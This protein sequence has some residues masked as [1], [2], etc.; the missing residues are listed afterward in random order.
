MPET[1][2]NSGLLARFKARYAANLARTGDVRHK[3]LAVA[4]ILL[5]VCL[6]GAYKVIWR[7]SAGERFPITITPGVMPACDSSP[8]RRLLR[9]VL[10]ALPAAR[11]AGVTVVKLGAFTETGFVPVT[12]KGTEM[13]LCS[14]DVFLTSGRHDVAFTL[15][16]TSSARNELWIEADDP[17]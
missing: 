6:F 8:S 16:W 5:G 12:A 17:F 9:Q 11:Q 1:A 10:E 3:Q 15:Q 7:P 4:G 2:S 13:R 14:G